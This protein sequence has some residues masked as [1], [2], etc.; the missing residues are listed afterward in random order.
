MFVLLTGW[1]SIDTAE[2]TGGD[3]LSLRTVQGWFETRGVGHRVAM[4]ANFRAR[5]E[6]D[7]ATVDPRQVSD[8]VFVCGPAAGAQ[9][10]ELLDRF[11]ASASPP[12]GR[13][14]GRWHRPAVG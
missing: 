2:V 7:W 4:A 6:L 5:D 12:G 1:F 13:V 11:P 10:E 14:G 3:L 9:V 8:V